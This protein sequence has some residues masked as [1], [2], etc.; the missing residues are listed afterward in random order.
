M[1]KAILGI[2]LLATPG[3]GDDEIK[4]K[5]GDRIS[6]TVT[7]M[8]K[9]KLE[10]TTAH[11]GKLQIDWAQVVSVKTDAKVKVKVETGELFEGKLSPG[12][13]GRLKVETEGAAQPVE[14]DLAKV[15]YLNEP[16]VTWHGNINLGG[17]ATDGNTHTKSFLATAE[18]QRATEMDLFLIRAIFR[19]GEDDGGVTE[20]NGYGLGKYQHTLFLANLY[21]YASIELLSD[22]FK[23][24]DLRTIV[25]LGVGYTFLKESWI[26]FSAEAGLAYTDNNFREL[27]EDESH[28]G[29]R[30]SSYLRVALPLGFEF[31]DLFTFYPNF[32]DTADWQLRNE[33]T[34][35]TAL[36]GG[37]T[38][39]G[40]V[41]SEVDNE[42][43]PGLVEYDDTYFVGLGY[44]F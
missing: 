33:A 16:P 9:N 13:E 31:K 30:L 25:S 1:R 40:G 6:G 23:D 3:F 42:P 35:G 21:G 17:R 41:I 15:K 22:R 4:L 37:W 24:L 19:Y 8:A 7:G 10:V 44:V 34:L 5:N 2:L 27:E 38:L 20:R 11:S 29:A 36:G 14:V 28:M 43:G 12:Q 32:E 26:D 39:L 18:L